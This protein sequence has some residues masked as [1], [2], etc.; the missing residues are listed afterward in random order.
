MTKAEVRARARELGLANAEKPDSQEICFVPD[1][2]YARFV[3]RSGGAGASSSWPYRRSQRDGRW[4]PTT[5]CI[6]LPSGSAAGW[7]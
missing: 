5:E 4:H 6:V 3:E 1:G 7:A 2:D